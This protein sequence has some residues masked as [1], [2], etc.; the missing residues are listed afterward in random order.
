MTRV[1][2]SADLDGELVFL[3]SSWMKLMQSAQVTHFEEHW[4]ELQGPE[5]K[6]LPTG[7]L[8]SQVKS[9]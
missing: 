9:P 6:M 2:D 1:S 3:T 7:L 4:S 8:N 5:N